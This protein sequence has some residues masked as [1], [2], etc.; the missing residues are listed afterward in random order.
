VGERILVV[1]SGAREHALVW[2]LAQ[3]RRTEALWC[4]PGNAGTAAIAETVAVEATDLMGLVATASQLRI[5]L[6]VVGPEAPLAAGLADRLADAGVRV[7]G[8]SGAASRIESSKAWAKEVMAEAQVPTARAVVVRSLREGISALSDF[9]WPVVVKADGLAAGKGVVIAADRAE[10]EEALIAFLEAGSLG[11]AGRVV[12]LEECLTGRE[13]S[14]L[15]LTDGESV[16][17]LPAACD[18]KRAFDGERGPNTGGMGAYSPVPTLSAVG[19]GEIQRTILAPTVAALAA[20]GTPL[21]GVLYAGLMLTAGGPMTLE[22]NAR[23]G[24]PETQVILPLLDADLAEMLAAVADGALGDVAPPKTADGAAVAVVLAS[25]GYP[26]PFRT[27]VPI[28]GLDRVPEDVLVFH[29]G[30][31]R[32]DVGRTVTAGGRVLTVVGRGATIAD[33]RKRAYAGAEAIS[34]AGRQIRSDIA[35]RETLA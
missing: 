12:V 26:G 23:F 8:A 3:S 17:P 25:G 30:T 2:K 19:L 22:F 20:R 33:A 27:G 7:C 29:A 35:L 5:E 24:D 14:V 31:T 18:Y 1:G 28:E 16:M 32:D 13:V 4:A 15:A 6:V 34:F 9:D 11:E 10:A 21:R